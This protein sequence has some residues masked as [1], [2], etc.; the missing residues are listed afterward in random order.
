MITKDN[1]SL[2]ID[3]MLFLKIG[4]PE[5]AS[6]KIENPEM[7]IKLLALTVMRSKIGM[8]KLGTLL[9]LFR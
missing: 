9:G 8:M 4:N 5:K 1:V 7:S 3:G 2:Q 6:Y